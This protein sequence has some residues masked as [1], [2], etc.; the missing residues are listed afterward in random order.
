MGR[1][2]HWRAMMGQRWFTLFVGMMPATGLA[3]PPVPSP[4]ANPGSPE[5]VA[6]GKALFFDEQLSSDHT[7]ACATCHQL[8]A[9]GTDPR[10][11]VHP[12]GDG[13][14]G[15]VDD[16]FGS[17]GVI[18]MDGE[19]RYVSDMLFGDTPQVTPRTTQTVFVAPWGDFTFWD[20]RAGPTFSDPQTGVER[21][22]DFGALEAQAMGPILNEGEMAHAGRDWVD[23]A[24]Q[25]R[26]AVAL[27]LATDL[28]PDL[29][30]PAPVTY[31]AWFE[32]V[33]GDDAITP[34]RIAYALGAY[35]RTLN[36]NQTPYDAF[37]NGDSNAL[38][39]AQIRGF[40]F[41]R[42]ALC[43]NCHIPPE[44]T[45]FRFRNV[46]I[47]P[48]ASDSGRQGVTGDP[49]DRG[50]FKV[51]S[52]RQ[53]RDR[54]RFMHTGSLSSLEEVL[55]FYNGTGATQFPTNQDFLVP[56]IDIDPTMLPDLL[57]F[58]RNALEDPR[59]EPGLGPF[60]RAGLHA[61]ID[62]CSDGIDNDGDGLSDA[63]DPG[64]HSAA[65]TS[66]LSHLDACD[67]GRDND[68]DGLVDGMDLDCDDLCVGNDALGDADGDGT[69]DDLDVVLSV[70]AARSNEVMHIDLTGVPATAS[71]VVLVSLQGP[72]SGP[73]HPNGSICADIR[74]PIVLRAGRTHVEVDVPASISAGRTLWFQAA[75]TD[76]STGETSNVVRRV[77][78]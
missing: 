64:C 16:L 58:L 49:S 51:P 43:S 15:T 72:G 22:L 29:M 62:A 33:Y 63:M 10:P 74:A 5:Q 24:N 3:M 41:Y 8:D 42:S 27:E 7:V 36:P 73:C 14:F 59:V 70:T 37:S 67:D 57:D 12:G 4:S 38:T 45:D 66:E 28:P 71:P 39:Q 78:E 17:P 20:G 53:V 77:V 34:T 21:I 56:R 35:Q 75:W 44:F 52:L 50:G 13:Q 69:C 1:A 2:P 19:R 65:D 6:L 40:Q 23:V 61:T 76:G 9:G 31:G 68:G 48:P 46:G 47:S 55:D 32:S 25:L 30:M 18:R 11:G 26:G 60:S 54:D